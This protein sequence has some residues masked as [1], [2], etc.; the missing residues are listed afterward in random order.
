MTAIPQ[1]LIDLIDVDFPRAKPDDIALIRCNGEMVT[2][3]QLEK[4]KDLARATPLPHPTIL[5]R[6]Y[7]AG[8]RVVL[9]C[10]PEIC[11]FNR[12]YAA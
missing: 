1:D 6:I 2:N 3:A 11:F 7:Y 12:K 4:Q 8:K 10:I 5:E 9:S